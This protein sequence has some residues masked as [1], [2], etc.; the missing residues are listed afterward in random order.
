MQNA[1]I[2]VN[3]Q[4]PVKKWL[5]A[6]IYTNYNYNLFEGPVNG[7]YIKTSAANLMFNVNNQFK[8]DKGWSAELSGWYRT[9]GVEGQILIQP[10]GSA[11]MG[12]SKQ[13]LKQKGSLRFNIRDIFYTQYPRGH[14]NFQNTEAYF[15]NRRDSRV[16][17]LTFSYRFGKP[18]KDQ[19]QRRKVGGADDEQNRV[20][21][22]SGN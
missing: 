17:N 20:N 7:E 19:R 1:G 9:K 11:S 4:F 3:L 14:I 2:A 21:V 5:T 16:A 6:M 22:G 10:M 18:I 13:I 12:V 15:E 8:F